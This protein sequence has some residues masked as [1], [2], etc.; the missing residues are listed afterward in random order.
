MCS[1]DRYSCIQE[2]LFRSMN[3]AIVRQ[4]P[5]SQIPFL[6]M[7]HIL[8]PM[9][10]A[11]RIFNSLL[12]SIV[13]LFS[14]VKLIRGHECPWLAHILLSAQKKTTFQFKHSRISTSIGGII[15]VGLS[16]KEKRWHFGRSLI[17]PYK[18]C[19]AH[20]CRKLASPRILITLLVKVRALVSFL[21]AEIWVLLKKSR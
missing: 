12:K 13:L 10:W 14:Y 18:L 6:A 2:N 20:L 8:Q 5:C 3:D 11:P 16:T 21:S 1:R 17:Q 4:L 9:G 15:L 19:E 7:S